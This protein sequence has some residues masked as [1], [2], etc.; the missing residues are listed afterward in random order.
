MEIDRKIGAFL[1]MMFTAAACGPQKWVTTLAAFLA[2]VHFVINFFASKTRGKL[3]LDDGE[4]HAMML[5]GEDKEQ[6]ERHPFIVIE[7][8]GGTR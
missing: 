1:V 8:R 3:T 2:A 4:G 5:L 7:I 6:L